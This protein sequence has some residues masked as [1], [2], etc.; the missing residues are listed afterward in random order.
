MIIDIFKDSPLFLGLQKYNITLQE[1]GA[2]HEYGSGK[3]SSYWFDTNNARSLPLS[4][5]NPYADPKIVAD[6][7]Y[8]LVL[9]VSNYMSL[10]LLQLLY[11]D[12][13]DILIEDFGCGAGWFIYYASKQGFN[14]FHMFENWTQVDRHLFEDVMK[15][16]EIKYALN[17]KNTNP[18]FINSS[19]SPFVFITYGL[20]D[21]DGL[22]Y[23]RDLSNT[24]MLCF[25]TNRDWENNLAHK[26]LPKRGFRFLCKDRGDLAVSWVREDKY[27][28]FK[29]RLDIYEV[30]STI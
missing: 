10:F 28:E 27:K 23:K 20:D 6:D 21:R 19:G 14:N 22:T 1:V 4:R 29:E 9:Y 26:A 13:K 17:D 2:K 24:E 15:K 11:Q 16:G 5:T 12:R 30:N 3:P 18:V 25:Y 7:R 8:C